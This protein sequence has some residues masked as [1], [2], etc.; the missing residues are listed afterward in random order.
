MKHFTALLTI[1]LF[2]NFSFGQSENYTALWQEVT[3]FEAQGLPKSALEVVS[4]ISNLA[5]KENN[6]TQRIK[7]LIYESKYALTLEEDAQLSIINNF[8]SEIAISQ[9]PTKTC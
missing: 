9:A 4:K 1:F 7:C 5:E 6:A 3:K 8:K 2:A